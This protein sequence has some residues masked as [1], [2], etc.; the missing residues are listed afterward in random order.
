[1][2]FADTTA[3]DGG[4]EVDRVKDPSP[5]EDGYWQGLIRADS[6]DALDEVG[7]TDMG[8]SFNKHAYRVRQR[9][10]Q[11]AVRESGVLEAGGKVFEAG[12]GVGFYI[13]LWQRA[14]AVVMG[15]DISPRAVANVRTR[16]PSYDLRESDLVSLHQWSDWS[17]L[18]E[19][20]DLVTAI[21]VLYHIVDDEMATIALNNLA[22]LVRPGGVL[23]VTEKFPE[24]DTT[25]R[26]HVHVTRRPLRWYT[27]V[28]NCQRIVVERIAPV[29]W[30]MDPALPN[31]RRSLGDHA[32]RALW[33]GLRASTK[34]FPRRSR[35]QERFGSL[36]G[37]IGGSLDRAL[38]GRAR[39]TGNLRIVTMRRIG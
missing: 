11:D 33:I 16:F 36:G 10:M 19:S 31:A 3:R 37:F 4:V 34:Y 9:A 23:L 35:I 39:S 25:V 7:H 6:P 38:V 30:C 14:N 22:A 26:E 29:F 17:V 32:A 12:F 2:T 21:D 18:V 20:F 24:H 15:A 8:R 13:P 27:D 1:V 5:G 28:T